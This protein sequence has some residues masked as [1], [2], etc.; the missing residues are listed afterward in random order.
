MG[1]GES[2]RL[3]I[4]PLST[5]YHLLQAFSTHHAAVLIGYGAHAICPYLAYETARQWRLSSRT[6]AL[7]KTG[8]VPDVSIEA[9]QVGWRGF[10]THYL[11]CLTGV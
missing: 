11:Q 8:K 9:A 10:F 3:V 2:G 6:Q 4:D 1:R 5:L 7:I